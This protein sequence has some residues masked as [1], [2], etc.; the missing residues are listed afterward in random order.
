MADDKSPRD[1]DFVELA[2]KVAR[3]SLDDDVAGLSAELAYR[4]LLALFPFAIFVAAL[5]AFVAASL[6]L[7]NPTEEILA[8]LRSLLPE[9]AAAL[10]AGQIESVIAGRSIAL[11]S[12]GVVLA[13]FFATGGMNAVIKALNRA[14]DVGE[15]RPIWRRYPMAAA[16]TVLAGTGMISAFTLFG[17]IRLFAQDLAELLGFSGIG[18]TVLDGLAIV[19]SLVLVVLAA[20]I[21]YRIAPNIRLPVRS[22]I[23]GALMFGIAWLA[24]TVV[25]NFYVSNFGNYANTYGALGGV[26]VLLIWFYVSALLFLVGAEINAAIH[27]MTA[28]ADIER[29]REESRQKVANSKE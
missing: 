20:T 12:I 19:I 7:E 3:H 14:Y 16:L 25:L 9:Q 2:K 26:V 4:F 17:P 10:V 1:L 27:R 29:R 8:T 18:G 21:V 24:A 5:G 22:L 28:P 6:P 23:P 13:L 11:P 15:G